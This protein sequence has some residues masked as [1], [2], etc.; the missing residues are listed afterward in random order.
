MNLLNDFRVEKIC[1]YKNEKYSVRDNGAIYRH[2]CF[3]KNKRLLDNR[4][5]FGRAGRGGYLYIAGVPAHRIVATAFHGESPQPDMVVDHRD[6]NKQNNRPENL[7]WVTKEENILNNPNTIRKIEYITGRPINEVLKNPKILREANKNK[8]N[9]SWM[10][11]VSKEEAKN[12]QKWQK[13]WLND[14]KKCS[15]GA[16]GEWV[17]SSFDRKKD[18]VVETILEDIR[19]TVK[20]DSWRPKGIKEQTVISD[21]LQSDKIETSENKYF[22][23]SL[24]ENAKQSWITP[25]EFLCCPRL[26]EEQS[27]EQYINNL[28]NGKI[29]SANEYFKTKIDNYIVSTEKKVLIVRLSKT[30][31]NSPLG[32][33]EILCKDGVFLHIDTGTLT[34]N[35]SQDWKTPSE[36][37][38]CPKFDEEQSLQQYSK[39]LEIGGIF[40]RNVYGLAKIINF[41]HDSEKGLII[42]E[43]CA[44]S[45][46][47]ERYKLIRITYE[48][49]TFFHDTIGSYHTREGGDKYFTLKIGKEWTGGDVFDDFC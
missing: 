21:Y 5:T 20:P 24:N 48:H 10:R 27:L 47:I 18:E 46:V 25:T 37:L 16:M 35:T 29:F 23:D 34:P 36:F 22:Y 13:Y 44:D 4:W 11:P 31:T 39:N 7:R 33:L 14:D 8:Q 6:T 3:D 41:F 45:A 15:N 32:L 28:K 9:T 2:S 40:S 43:I 49:Q 19:N 12:L 38:C 17:F 26:D 1:N 30:D 42:I